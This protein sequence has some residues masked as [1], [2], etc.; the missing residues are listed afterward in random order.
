MKILINLFLFSFLIVACQPQTDN[1]TSASGIDTTRIAADIE[2]LASD[3][4]LGRKPFTEGEKLTLEFL[5]SSY[6]EIGLLPGNG[7]SYFQEVPLVEIDPYPEDVLTVSSANGKLE[8]KKGSEFVAFSER[9]AEEA[10]IES[11][12][13]V[14]AGFGIVAPEYNWND[15]E[16]LDVKGKTVIVLVND[17]GFGSDDPDFFKGQTMTYYGRWTYKYEEAARQGAAGI[18]IIHDTAPAGYQWLVGEEQLD[19]CTIIP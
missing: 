16:G 13:L 18:L 11:S 6:K 19:R 8:L 14:F 4:F 5:E 1:Q 17:P 10:S 12:E 15:Y 9:V 2:T 7:D 3:K